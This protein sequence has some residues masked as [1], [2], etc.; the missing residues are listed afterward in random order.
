MNSK[1]SV[2]AYVKKFLLSW[3]EK[4]LNTSILELVASRFEKLITF[5]CPYEHSYEQPKKRRLLTF[6]KRII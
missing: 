1:N 4:S 6:I 5:N 3:N 2:K